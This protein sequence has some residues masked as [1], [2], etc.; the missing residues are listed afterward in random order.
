MKNLTKVLSTACL[1]CLLIAMGCQSINQTRTRERKPVVAPKDKPFTAGSDSCKIGLFAKIGVHKKGFK[2][3]S[4]IYNLENGYSEIV[5]P[6]GYKGKL[7]TFEPAPDSTRPYPGTY[8]AEWKVITTNETLGASAR[9]TAADIVENFKKA[10]KGWKLKDRGAPN[11]TDHTFTAEWLPDN[12][13]CVPNNPS[14]SHSFKVVHAGKTPGVDQL[15]LGEFYK[16]HI[17]KKLKGKKGGSGSKT[18]VFHDEP[19][20][21]K[22]VKIKNKKKKKKK[23][24]NDEDKVL[25]ENF[26]YYYTVPVGIFWDFGPDCCGL[27][28][29][30]PKVIQFARAV[31]SGP[32]GN[33]GKPWTLDISYGNQKNLDKINKLEHD[34]TYTSIP[35]KD[36]NENPKSG[37]GGTRKVGKGL[38]QWDA[39]GAPESLYERLFHAEGKSVY[40]QQFLSLLVCRPRPKI[41]S[42]KMHQTDYYMDYSLVKEIAV[43][44]ITWDFPGQKGV[45]RTKPDQLKPPKISFTFKTIDGK[46]KLLKDFIAKN[47]LTDKIQNPKDVERVLKILDKDDYQKLI[48]DVLSWEQSPDKNVKL[49]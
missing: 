34:P 31:I 41:I 42:K 13:E 46:C 9:G 35:G 18:R 2:T 8:S 1:L 47:G 23:K 49:P 28:K 15:K 24:D 12:V 22:K 19:A 5:V 38:S 45:D 14:I 21:P 3:P 30:E 39:P 25:F 33:Q 48:N 40:K 17:Q 4:Y 27:K 11:L 26:I 36:K 6:L 20:K 29:V 32:N 37:S 10:R 43:L 16:S 7:H 44:T